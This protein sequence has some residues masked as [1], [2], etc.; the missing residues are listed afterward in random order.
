MKHIKVLGSGCKNCITTADLIARK[1]KELDVDVDVEK[2]TDM[3]QIMGYGAM[4]TPGVVIDEKLVHAGGVPA[5][6]LVSKWLTS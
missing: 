2:V 5:P 1:A 4:S 6:Q 3:A